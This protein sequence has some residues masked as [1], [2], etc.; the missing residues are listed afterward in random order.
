MKRVTRPIVRQIDRA[1]AI[2]VTVGGLGI[3]AAVLVIMVYLAA[4]VVPLFRQ[5]VLFGQRGG[6]V[7]FA[8]GV[9]PLDAVS[10]EYKGLMVALLP[11]GTAQ[12]VDL[13]TFVAAAPLAGGER[14][15]GVA[16]SAVSAVNES[17]QVVVGYADGSVQVG[18]IGTKSSFV[19]GADIDR[20]TEEGKKAAAMRS[21]ERCAYGGGGGYA[22]MTPLGQLRVVSADFSLSKAVALEGGSGAVVRADIRS[23]SSSEFMVTARADG[24]VAFSRVSE[25]KPMGGGKPRTT[26]ASVAVDFAPP[27]GLSKVPDYLFSTGDGTNILALWKGGTAQRYSLMTKGDDDAFVLAETTGL[28]RSGRTVVSARMLLGSRTLLIGDDAGSVVCA[29]AARRDTMRTPDGRELV[30]GHTLEGLTGEGTVASALGIALRDRS[31]VL[32]DSRGGV[33]VR[34]VTS[35]KRVAQKSAVLGGGEPVAVAAVTPKG[36]GVVTIGKA[37]NVAVL[38]LDPG[39]AEVSVKA[40]FGKVWYEGDAEP[41]FT[42]QAATGEDTAETKFSNVPLVFGTVKSTIYSMLFAIPLAVA[43]A[44]YT[45]EFLHP[46][47]KNRVKPVIEMMASLPSVVLGFLASIVIA[48]IFAEHLPGVL[49]AFFVVP[50]GVLT[51][52]YLWQLVP[53]RLSTRLTSLQHIGMVLCVVLLSGVASVGLGKLMERMLFTPSTADTLVL[54]GSTQEVPREQ[55]PEALRDKRSISGPDVLPYRSQGLYYAAGKIVRPTGSVDDPKVRE[56][57]QKNELHHADMRAWLDGLIGTPRAG[58]VLVM[59]PVGVLLAAMLR[60][61]FVDAKLAAVLPRVGTAAATTE[62]GKFAGTLLTGIG[63]AGLLATVL[64]A[65][66]FDARDSLIG[67]FSARNTLVVG[68]AMGFAIIP[69]IYTI[70]E[71]SLSAVPGQLRS[72]SLGCGATRWQTATRVV[73]PIA[74]SGIFSAIMIGLGRAAGETMIVLMATGNTP[75][76]DWNIFSGFRTL[77]ANIATEMPEA[78]VGGTHYRILFLGALLLFALTFLVNT[79]AEMVR[80]RVRRARAAL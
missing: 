4:T 46:R 16:V 79:L 75:N 42:Y 20:S 59:T 47:V 76:M 38:D 51:G 54:A 43:A 72:A 74:L 17:G 53:I 37:G 48:P 39:F 41:S 35:E 52:A 24:T 9:T 3:I 33:T 56:V 61:R 26:L 25:V 13:Q 60:S 69:I 58:W 57:I 18:R 11:D 71:D 30:A 65:M 32:G 29:F 8:G 67:S 68:V 45:S 78:D 34:H 31:V 7:A 6:K 1:G 70:S 15:A 40:I 28:L 62:I 36:D 63:I 27:A 64:S 73:L 50:V 49:M 19:E 66:G 22:E 2:G 77:S 23:A 5:G 12:P 80:Q 10:D 21:G 55:Y 44:L 14:P